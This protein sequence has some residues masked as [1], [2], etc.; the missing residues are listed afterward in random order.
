[1]RGGARCVAV[2]CCVLQ[3]GVLLCC[4]VRGCASWADPLLNV[5]VRCPMNVACRVAVVVGRCE[6][7]VVGV[8]VKGPVSLVHPRLNKSEPY[9]CA[10]ASV[11]VRV[12][13]GRCTI[14]TSITIR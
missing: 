3:S 10:T 9:V 7:G 12:C 2:G 1:M 5:V 4:R 14:D 8:V 6:R 13:V 11:C